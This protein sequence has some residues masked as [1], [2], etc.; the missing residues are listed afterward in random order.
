M[1]WK[2]KSVENTNLENDPRTIDLNNSIVGTPID[3]VTDYEVVID[4]S[5]FGEIDA[6][7]DP[8]YRDVVYDSGQSSHKT[9][10][11]K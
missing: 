8:G 3:M 9:G 1:T 4:Y 6:D 2:K 5:G 7:M 10:Q 11:E